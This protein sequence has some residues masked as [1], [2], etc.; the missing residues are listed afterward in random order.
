M[1]KFFKSNINRQYA[2]LGMGRFGVEMVK[3]LNKSGCEVLALDIDE[4]KLSEVADIAT[5][6]IA[7]DASDEAVLKSLSIASFDVVIIAIGDN[8]QSSLIAAMTCKD[9]GAKYIVAKANNEKHAKILRKIGVDRIVVPEADSAVKTA[10][11]LNN[12]HV[13]EIMEMEEGYCIAEI[14]APESWLNKPLSDLRVRN[15]YNVNVLM[16]IS[17]K[18][19]V[20]SPTAETVFISGDKVIIGGLQSDIKDF[21]SK[22]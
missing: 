9:L 21:I 8:I 17:R 18:D 6:T 11:L 7:A 15:K 19:G 22:F 2:V 5:H 13:S 1:L 3:A 20:V 12:P 4:D 16:R 14:D 10:T